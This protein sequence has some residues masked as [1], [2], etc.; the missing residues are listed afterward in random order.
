MS[1]LGAVPDVAPP[2]TEAMAEIDLRCVNTVSDRVS[3]RMR[4]FVEVGPM[5]CIACFGTAVAHTDR[6]RESRQCRRLLPRQLRG[7]AAHREKRQAQPLQDLAKP[8]CAVTKSVEV[9]L[10]VRHCPGPHS[11]KAMAG[12]HSEPN[13][14]SAIWC[15]RFPGRTQAC[16]SCSV[17]QHPDTVYTTRPT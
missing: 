11:P 13:L 6:R 8:T 15:G 2:T 12:R 10:L 4:A 7:K 14:I 9:P 3:R 5:W 16:V 1:E 17:W